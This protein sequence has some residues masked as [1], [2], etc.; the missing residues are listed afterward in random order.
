MLSVSKRR[1]SK[2]LDAEGEII[3]M[4]AD[5][6]RQISRRRNRWL[7]VLAAT[8]LL[9]AI[10]LV[11]I[12][13]DYFSLRANLSRSPQ[14]FVTA[15]HGGLPNLNDPTEV[16]IRLDDR[17]GATWHMTAFHDSEFHEGEPFDDGIERLEGLVDIPDRD[18]FGQLGVYTNVL[19]PQS[20][21]A[22]GSLVMMWFTTGAHAR[23][24]IMAEED[25]FVDP[26]V[27]R[28]RDT[29]WMGSFLVH[30]SPVGAQVDR[31]EGLRAFFPYFVQCPMSSGECEAPPELVAFDDWVERGAV[32]K[33]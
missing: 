29:Y 20:V 27:E 13:R 30:Y 32:G 24:A 26:A 5:E 11:F 7:I 4:S 8:L 1:S 14:E 2:Y 16:F 12:A 23:R 9:G 18:E 21:Q 33:R 25:V 15:Y 3:P 28:E 6:L 22:N 19:D 10:A 17:S 31:T